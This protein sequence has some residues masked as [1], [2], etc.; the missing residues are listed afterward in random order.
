MR[1]L[2]FT[3]MAQRDPHVEPGMVF[4]ANPLDQHHYR[5]THVF[6]NCVYYLLVTAA[7]SFRDCGKPLRLGRA[8]LDR[9]CGDKNAAWGHLQLP[10][11]FSS[12][13]EAGT[14]RAAKM[15]KLWHWIKPL[16]KDFDSEEILAKHYTPRIESLADELGENWLSVRRALSCYY[17][18]GR[19]KW[20]LG[21]LVRGP[22]PTTV[23]EKAGRASKKATPA[24]TPIFEGKSDKRR[25]G[26][27]S[28]ET[29]AKGEH[30]I[31]FDAQ[32]VKDMEQTLKAALTPPCQRMTMAAISETYLY[33]K[34]K[35]RYPE[36]FVAWDDQKKTDIPVTPRLFRWRTRHVDLN[37]AQQANLH[38]PPALADT[39][40]LRAKGPNEICEADGT[41]GRVWLMA[42]HGDSYVSIGKCNIYVF[43][44]RWS[45]FVH[46]VHITLHNNSSQQLRKALE[47]AFTP[48]QERYARLGLHVTEERWPRSYPPTEFTVDRGPD[49][50]SKQVVVS[51]VE[52]LR[53]KYTP[54]PAYSPDAKG[55]VERFIQ[56]L[57]LRMSEKLQGAFSRAMHSRETKIAA[58]WAHDAAVETLQDAYRALI[59][60]VMEYNN[61]THEGLEESGVMKTSGLAPTP[62]NAYRWGM[63]TITGCRTSP[64][65]PDQF[66]KML[67]SNDT[68]KLRQGVM[69]YRSYAYVPADPL[70]VQQAHERPGVKRAVKIKVDAD[71]VNLYMIV[72]A[73]RLAHFRATEKTLA[74]MGKLTPEEDDALKPHNSGVKHAHI[75]ETR[76]EKA[77]AHFARSPKPKSLPVTTVD[78]TQRRELRLRDQNELEGLLDGKATH[79]PPAVAP[80][81]QASA[82]GATTDPATVGWQERNRNK[83]AERLRAFR[84]QQ[85]SKD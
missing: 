42:R 24:V 16:V 56:T 57:K 74:K 48:R 36:A 30:T 21:G 58:Q 10:D 66:A 77:K 51:V 25:P 14:D 29:K 61:Q 45:R 71:R 1:L 70:A 49:F 85:A 38:R 33:G 26:R 39:G 23:F 7:S 83:A 69:V 12:A 19:W 31:V 60:I 82:A 41:G 81:P 28:G 34:F 67:L 53:I 75:A 3:P 11:V 43:I 55:I 13:P 47:Y 64:F 46:G 15:E 9:L 18:F 44:D 54:L 62:A 40:H 20:A 35:E 78:E 68:A 73:N 52:H 32:D 76:R 17:Y 79:P 27:K 63:E 84:E 65:S 6:P 80:A 8:D 59:E 5:I 2:A 4:R 50:L 72:G 22:V 37:E